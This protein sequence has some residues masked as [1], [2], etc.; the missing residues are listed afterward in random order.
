MLNCY[1]SIGEYFRNFLVTLINLLF[2]STAKCNDAFS[3]NV[4]IPLLSKR[5]YLYSLYT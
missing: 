5:V 3:G 1:N 4:I 2:V